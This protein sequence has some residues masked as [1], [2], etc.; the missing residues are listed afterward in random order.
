MEHICE[1]SMTICQRGSIIKSPWQ[2]SIGAACK[3]SMR[4]S[5]WDRIIMYIYDSLPVE[6]D[7]EV[8]TKVS[9]WGSAIKSA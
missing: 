4:V 7:Y 5:Q 6:Q 3:V 2:S 9:H 8:C 1:V